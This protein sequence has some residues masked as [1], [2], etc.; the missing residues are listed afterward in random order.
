VTARAHLGAEA[1]SADF[2]SRDRVT[3]HRIAAPGDCGDAEENEWRKRIR[4]KAVAAC[5]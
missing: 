5:T 3:P 4:R 1:G 2:S